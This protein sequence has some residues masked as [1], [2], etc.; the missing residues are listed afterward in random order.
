[1]QTSRISSDFTF[2]NAPNDDPYR[3]VVTVYDDVALP[4]LL[5]VVVSAI[6]VGAAGCCTATAGPAGLVGTEATG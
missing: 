3:Q 1:Y 4:P 6:A 5:L 2:G